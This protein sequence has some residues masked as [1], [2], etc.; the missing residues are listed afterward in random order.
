MIKIF[1]LWI[2]GDVCFFIDNLTVEQKKVLTLHSNELFSG[3]II[4]NDNN[5]NKFIEKTYEKFGII[6][7]RVEV[8]D[9]ITIK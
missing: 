4:L 9:V 1:E 6:L 5:I 3:N 7:E 2:E 8:S